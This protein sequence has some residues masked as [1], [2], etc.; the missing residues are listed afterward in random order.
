MILER[1][2]SYYI[3]PKKSAA[4]PLFD[5]RLNSYTTLILESILGGNILILGRMYSYYTDPRKGVVG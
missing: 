5:H 4:E 2:H 3:E 1:I